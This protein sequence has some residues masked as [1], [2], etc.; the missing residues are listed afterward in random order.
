MKTSKELFD[1]AQKFI[2]GG[3]NSPVRACK[4]VDSYPLFIKR[5]KGSKIV[6][7]E[8]QEFVDYVMSWGPLILGHAHPEVIA[9]AIEALIF[10]SS[11]GAPCEWELKLAEL[12]VKHVPSVEM[13]RMVNSG[14]EATMSAIRLARAYTKKNK[15]V[16][17]TGCYHG[18]VDSLLAEAGS[19]VATFS[20]PGTPGIPPKVVE[21]TIL[22]PYNDIEAVKKVFESCDDIACVIVEP[23][24]GN[25]GVVLPE[26]GF[27]EFLRTITKENHAVLIFD[28]V[29]T[30]FRVSINGAQGRFGVEPDLTC[31]GKIIGGGFPVG[32]FGGKKE[33]MQ[34][35]AP[36]GN[37]YQAGTLS[38]NPVAMAAG[39]AT[40]KV[41][42]KMDYQDLENR[43]SSLVEE[44]KTIFEKKS[45]PVKINHISSMFTVFFTEKEVKDFESAKSTDLSLFKQFYKHL[46]NNG[47]YIAPSNFECL[48]LSFAHTQEDLEK[49]IDVVKEFEPKKEES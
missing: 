11:Y 19:G 23:V 4:Q 10:G 36:L 34:H 46:R 14:T 9:C 39:Y 43:T 7:Y 40:L 25:M 18:H 38:G 17:F 15:V 35:I 44:L 20:I 33:I 5:G 49:T 32:A 24:A 29:I 6:S 3:V 13:V 45:I 27:L 31:L 30:G 2:P 42:E 16:K 1:Y 8:G 26:R 41:L 48:F 22:V 12:I 37:V 28:E 47:I 21:D